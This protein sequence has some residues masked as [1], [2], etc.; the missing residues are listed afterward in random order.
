MKVQI[1]I[2]GVPLSFKDQIEYDEPR[3][4]GGSHPEIEALL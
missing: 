3:V 4:I 1:F 2:S